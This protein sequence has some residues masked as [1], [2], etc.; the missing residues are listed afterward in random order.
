MTFPRGVEPER[1]EW[2]LA[3]TE[4]QAVAQTL[5]LE[6]PRIVAPAQGTLIAL[7]PDIPPSRQRIVFEARVLDGTTR[8]I[9]DGADLGAG[10]TPV[11]LEANPRT[12]YARTRR[13]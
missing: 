5:A 6:Q 8:W 13:P 10:L 12:A 2:F 3:G 9:L 7:D 11:G 1:A 4:P